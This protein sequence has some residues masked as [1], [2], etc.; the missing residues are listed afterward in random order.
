MCVGTPA[1]D[2]ANDELDFFAEAIFDEMPIIGFVPGHFP[3]LGGIAYA[4]NCGVKLPFPSSRNDNVTRNASNPKL[5][6]RPNS[7]EGSLLIQVHTYARG[8]SLRLG[9]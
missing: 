8:A 5:G 6:R 4:I 2:E 9:V 7:V 3:N 1:E